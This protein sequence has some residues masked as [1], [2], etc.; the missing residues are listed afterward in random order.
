MRLHLV[1]ASVDNTD[2]KVR[3][4]LLEILFNNQYHQSLLSKNIALGCDTA[5]FYI[6]VDGRDEEIH[7]GADGYYGNVIIYKNKLAYCIS[8]VP[9]SDFNNETEVEQLIRHLFHV[10]SEGE[11]VYPAA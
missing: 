7:T 9:D 3:D 1:I 11:W 6:N 5:R 4:T 2:Q 10:E 8:V